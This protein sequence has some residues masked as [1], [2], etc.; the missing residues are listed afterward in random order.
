MG[1]DDLAAVLKIVDNTLT[2]LEDSVLEEEP[3]VRRRKLE[4]L[5]RIQHLILIIISSCT[6]IC[7]MVFTILG[8]GSV[9]GTGSVLLVYHLT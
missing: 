1:G 5:V 3:P 7:I 6:S 2:V 4:N 8:I 9:T